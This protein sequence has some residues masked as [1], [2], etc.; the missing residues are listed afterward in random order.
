MA[1]ATVTSGFDEDSTATNL[2]I[3]I[4]DD[5]IDIED[6]DFLHEL[7]FDPAQAAARSGSFRRTGTLAQALD[8]TG[9]RFV[10]IGD[11]LLEDGLLDLE[12]DRLDVEDDLLQELDFGTAQAATPGRLDV[13]ND[14]QQELDLGTAQAAIR[15]RRARPPNKKTLQ[16]EA[17][18]AG[19][20]QALQAGG[21]QGQRDEALQALQAALQGQDVQDNVGV[22]QGKKRGRPVGSKDNASRKKKS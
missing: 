21:T 10:D 22:T 20:M 1:A 7:G 13:E 3:E 2:P 12:D 16:T 5:F 15:P 4:S 18:I 6:D 19:A 11:D 14:L 8:G 9:D 17:A